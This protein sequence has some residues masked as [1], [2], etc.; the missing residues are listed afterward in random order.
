MRSV[1]AAGYHKVLPNTV[2]S[3]LVA[4]AE[5]VELYLITKCSSPDVER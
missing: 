4:L 3:V 5:Q 1:N 2:V